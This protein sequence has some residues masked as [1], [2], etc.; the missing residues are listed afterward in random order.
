MDQRLLTYYDRELAHLRELGSEFAAEFPKIAGQLGLLA[1]DCSDPHV[2]RLLEGFAFL[3]AR[4][5]LKMD[6]EFPR[7]TE[8]LLDMIYPHCLAPTPA[9]TIVSFEPST[10]QIIGSQGFNLPRGTTLNT[11]APGHQPTMC[12]FRTAHELTLWPLAISS[13][14]HSAFT[15]DLGEIRLDGERKLRG[16]V[17]ILLRSTDGRPLNQLDL[18]RLPLFIRGQDAVGRRLYDLLSSSAVGMLVRS[19]EGTSAEIVR[20]AYIAPIGFEDTQA[21]LPYGPRSFQGYRLLQ[22]YFALPGRFM[23]LELLQL[24]KGLARASGAELEVIVLLDKHDSIVES[25]VSRAHVKLFC[26][27]AINLFER[28]ADRIQLSDRTHQYHVVADRTRPRDFEVHSITEVV[29]HAANNQER[30]Q[31]RPFYSC[32]ERTV[33]AADAAYFTVHREP[34]TASTRQR[35]GVTAS[36]Y[37]GSETFIELVDGAEGPYH[38]NLHQLSVSTLCTNRDLPL[39]APT[40]EGVTN[41]TLES[42][43]PTSSVG[44][45]GGLSAPRASNAWGGTSWRL[46]SHLSSNYLSVVGDGEGNGAAALREL[47][48]LH[49]DQTSSATQRQIQGLAS[50]TSTPVV[51]RL[52]LAGPVSFGRG[53]EVT[54]DVDEAAFEGTS[55]L[56]FGAVLENF[57]AKYAPINSFTELSLRGAERRELARFSARLGRR[58]G[59]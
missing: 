52:P 13:V 36:N 1:N 28:K 7:F 53:L 4:V 46:I 25:G 37:E 56:C 20:R 11:E 45:V 32:T 34:R 24:R 58:R 30:R 6:A 17:R 50:V 10:R 3:A 21:L 55:L 19:P 49:A 15:S 8:H 31:F 26:T 14:R 51:R 35:N 42:A 27:P 5:Q 12:R 48:Q 38:P 29:G 44:S 57:F 18:D 41:F 9:M 2:E 16:A 33:G 23:F 39:S 47:L 22:E 43:A 40:R 54:V 59:M